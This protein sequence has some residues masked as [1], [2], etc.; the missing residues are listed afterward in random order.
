[1]P[2]I[3]SSLHSSQLT[4]LYLDMRECMGHALGERERCVTQRKEMI[5]MLV[6]FIFGGEIVQGENLMLTMDADSGKDDPTVDS[7]SAV[8][9]ISKVLGELSREAANI[10]TDKEVRKTELRADLKRLKSKVRDAR[11][12]E[13]ELLERRRDIQKS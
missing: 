9:R 2:F 3:N 12:K 1:M 6:K 10:F 13:Q 7:M 11:A 8:S 4:S 5:A